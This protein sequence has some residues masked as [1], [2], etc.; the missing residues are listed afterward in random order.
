MI[1]MQDEVVAGIRTEH[2]K[3]PAVG[4]DRRSR[5]SFICTTLSLRDTLVK[6]VRRRI[7]SMATITDV[8]SV[9]EPSVGRSARASPSS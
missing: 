1:E 6:Y 7:A 4:T 3:A 9:F 2:Q 5:E 8:I